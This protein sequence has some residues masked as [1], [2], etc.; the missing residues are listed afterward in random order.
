MLSAP[1][2]IRSGCI[3]SWHFYRQP[4]CHIHSVQFGFNRDVFNLSFQG[5]PGLVGPEGLAGEPGKPGLPG[6]PGV[7][8][9]GLPVSVIHNATSLEGKKTA[10]TQLVDGGISQITLISLDSSYRWFHFDQEVFLLDAALRSA[11]QYLAGLLLF[12]QH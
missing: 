11:E 7:G 8:K 3:K 6:L 12:A 2:D 4:V 1:R 10:C 9:P 5:T